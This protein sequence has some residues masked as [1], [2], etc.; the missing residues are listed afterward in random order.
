[1]P[2]KGATEEV[3][4]ELTTFVPWHHS[5]GNHRIHFG[6]QIGKMVIAGGE[7]IRELSPDLGKAG[8]RYNQRCLATAKGVHGIG[9][10]N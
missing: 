5:R 3:P 9:D 7:G 2:A 6:P 4:N 8:N 1:V 10:K